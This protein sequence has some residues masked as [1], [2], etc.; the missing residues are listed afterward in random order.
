[1]ECF[2]VPGFG[3]VLIQVPPEVDCE[4]SENSLLEDARSIGGWQESEA[5]QECYIRFQWETRA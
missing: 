2:D 4:P 3:F 5:I 1:M